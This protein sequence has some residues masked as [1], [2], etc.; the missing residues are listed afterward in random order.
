MDAY[1][2]KKRK[3][4]GPQNSKLLGGKG[5]EESGEG[6]GQTGI[7]DELIVKGFWT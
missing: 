6:V 3:I 4:N 7:M 1:N 2:P 5:R